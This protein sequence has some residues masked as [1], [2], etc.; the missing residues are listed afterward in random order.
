MKEGRKPEAARPSDG[1]SKVGKWPCSRRMRCGDSPC[2]TVGWGVSGC[3][4][5]HSSLVVGGWGPVFG[6][7]VGELQP[8]TQTP[9]ESACPR[10]SEREGPRS[11]AAGG[12]HRA[13]K[14]GKRSPS[15]LTSAG[16]AQYTFRPTTARLSAFSRALPRLSRHPA[17]CTPVTPLH[18]QYDG[19]H[20]PQL[21][22][23][24]VAAAR[25]TCPTACNNPTAPLSHRRVDHK[26]E[27]EWLRVAHAVHSRSF[28]APV[29]VRGRGRRRL[30]GC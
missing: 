7:T 10:S 12:L 15:L 3:A 4:P 30:P 6:G 20:V 23:T 14:S 26:G 27:A 24:A 29:V 8:S 1:K 19:F 11:H 22:G 18:A 28:P 2:C 21:L 16:L 13:V 17:Q 9:E 25:T 5:S